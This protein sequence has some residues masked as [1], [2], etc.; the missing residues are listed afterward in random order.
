MEL[1]AGILP[2]DSN[3]ELFANPEKFGK[4]YW[5]SNGQTRQ[6]CELPERIMSALYKELYIDRKA[7]KALNE[8]GFSKESEMLEVYNYCNRGKLDVTP[9]ISTSGKLHKEYF[10]CGRHD[11]CPG[12]GKVCSRYGLTFR[13]RQCL[14]LAGIGKDYSQIKSEMGFRSKTAVNSLME[15]LRNKLGASNKSEL[16][17]RARQIGLV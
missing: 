11:R 4:C 3:I 17:V 13:E 9:D 12:D 1:P 15:R 16:A 8:M 14:M 5:I 2:N 6:F 7:V 10:D